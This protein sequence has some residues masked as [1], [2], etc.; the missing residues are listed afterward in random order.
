MSSSSAVGEA[1]ITRQVQVT[2]AGQLMAKLE[3]AMSG[4]TAHSDGK[5]AEVL[6]AFF[7]AALKMNLW[8]F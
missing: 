7:G 1:Q 4:L 3:E 8:L 5:L 6:G 2:Q